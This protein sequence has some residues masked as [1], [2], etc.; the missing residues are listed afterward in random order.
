MDMKFVEEHNAEAQ[1]AWDTF[2]TGKAHATAG[3]RVGTATADS[4]CTTMK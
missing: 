3:G 2:N 4:S 1:A